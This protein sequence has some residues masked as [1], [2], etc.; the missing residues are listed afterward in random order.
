M[1][2]VEFDV[3]PQIEF[4]PLIGREKSAVTDFANAADTPLLLAGRGFVTITLLLPE[5]VNADDGITAV[6][7]VALLT[8]TELAATPPKVTAAPETKF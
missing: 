7:V 4:G 1:N 8:V 6:I 3:L 2:A 5:V